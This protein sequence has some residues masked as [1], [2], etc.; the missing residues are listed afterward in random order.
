MIGNNFFCYL[1]DIY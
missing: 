1:E